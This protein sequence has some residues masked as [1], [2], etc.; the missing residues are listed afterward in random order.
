MAK[1]QSAFLCQSL[2][3]SDSGTFSALGIGISRFHVP[4]LPSVINFMAVAVVKWDRSEAER[5]HIAMFRVSVEDETIARATLTAPAPPWH[6][7]V[8]AG[9]DFAQ[10]LA[11]DARRA[12]YYD[13][14]VSIDGAELERL[15]LEITS[16][17]PAF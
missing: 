16:E 6:D 11:F 17:L 4:S 13:V 7:H 15:P 3:F 5:D 10:G 2:L 1:V 9:T 12:G 8:G 14:T